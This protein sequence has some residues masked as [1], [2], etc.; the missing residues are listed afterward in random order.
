MQLGA[1][2]Q[3]TPARHKSRTPGGGA[4]A[5]P[6]RISVKAGG[7]AGQRLKTDDGSKIMIPNAR[8]FQPGVSG[9]PG[10]RPKGIAAKAREHTDK[11]IEI[12]VAGLD[13]KDARVRLVAARE[14]LDRGYG[15]PLAMTAD[16]TRRLD[17]W[18]DDDIDAAIS[19]IKAA[20]PSA[21]DADDGAAEAVIN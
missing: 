17:D 4:L 14:L 21:G 16:V 9:N 12:L 2:N 15:K 5:D 20:L 6:M 11:A 8:K 19:A 10:G 1:R 13:D 7:R 3:L 18:T